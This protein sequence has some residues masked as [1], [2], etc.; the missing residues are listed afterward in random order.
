MN[1]A[2]LTK[3]AQVEFPGATWTSFDRY[4]R[5]GA[6]ARSVRACLGPG[7]VRVLDVGDSSGYLY[8][9][10]PDLHPI[11]LDIKPVADRLPDAVCLAG[12]GIALPFADATFDAVVSS[13]ALEHVPPANRKAFLLELI[14]VSRDVVVVAAPFDTPGVAGTEEMVR[15]FVL[16]ATGAPQVQLD[17][18]RDN[19]L[20][21]LEEAEE[22]L[23]GSGMATVTAGNGNLHDWLTMMLIKHQISARES[24]SPLASGYD[25]LYNAL[26]AGREHVAPFYRHVVVGRHRGPPELGVPLGL[27]DGT[28]GDISAILAVAAA[29]NVAEAARQD[30]V[31]P[32]HQLDRRLEGVGK[33]QDDIGSLLATIEGELGQLLH[34]LDEAT[35]RQV[36]CDEVI[37]S[38]L[39]SVQQMETRSQGTE[40]KIDHL[41]A[42]ARHPVR[43]LG[44]A[45]RR[46]LGK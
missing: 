23:A 17:E 26:F 4:A 38:L 24:L 27:L 15:H 18:H 46:G 2:A 7:V 25:I 20:P 28:P 14:R 29:T 43:A 32:I 33:H 36:A 30:I 21:N 5:Y 10:D 42:L 40:V 1:E 44:R 8:Q 39:T 35:G 34:R 11:S 31:P 3:H 12:D 6:I 22:I 19:G 45:M 13:D 37:R 9:F 16:L 41:V